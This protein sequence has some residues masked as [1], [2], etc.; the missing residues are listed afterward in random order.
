MSNLNLS[1]IQKLHQKK[2]RKLLGHFLV[3]GLHLVEE[4]E[5]SSFNDCNLYVTEKFARIES[6]F[7]KTILS[8]QQFKRL[9]EV[10]SHQGIAAIVP[11]ANLNRT[12]AHKKIIYINDLQ[13]PGNLGTL[14]RTAAWFNQFSIILSPDTVDPLN[15]KVIRSSMGAL[16]FVNVETDINIDTLMKRYERIACLDM[17]GKSI[18]SG[19]FADFDCYMIGN[20]A[21][22]IDSILKK[23]KQFTFFSITGD[24]QT[25][26]LNAAVAGSIAMFELNRRIV[27]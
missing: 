7:P 18:Q 25:E 1:E 8:E 9:S 16:F 15:A 5:K 23:S 4:L 6:R 21:K 24:P 13:D 19:S 11:I 10:K 2:Y 26:S 27:Q 20:E 14:I 22:G 3:E 12:K 17:G